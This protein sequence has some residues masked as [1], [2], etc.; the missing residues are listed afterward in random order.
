[1]QRLKPIGIIT[2]FLALGAAV[3]WVVSGNWS[4]IKRALLFTPTVYMTADDELQ[5]AIENNEVRAI[6]W[7]TLLP[8]AD[9]DAL[10]RYQ[11]APPSSM[12]DFTTQILRSIEASSDSA[13]QQAMTSAE[14]VDALNNTWVSIPGFLVPID[15]HADQSVRHVF[16]VPYFGACLHFPPP[17]PNQMIFARL[18]P[19]FSSLELTQPYQLQGRL[20]IATFEDPLGTSAYAMQVSAIQLFMGQP[21]DVRQH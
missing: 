17:P 20:S 19:G 14:V 15:F 5:H 2:L 9:R 13:Y 1:M 10:A 21:D 18:E 16:V 6:S 7:E 12:N 4:Q 8:A 11:Q 3:G